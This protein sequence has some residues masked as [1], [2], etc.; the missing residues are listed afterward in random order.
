MA[1]GYS[2]IQEIVVNDSASGAWLLLA[3]ALGKILTTSLTIGSGGSGGVFGPSMVIGGCGGAALGLALHNI[4]PDLV[5]HPA[6]FAVVGMASFFAAAAKTPFS[7]LVMVSEMTG[8]YHLLLPA[9]WGCTIS[10]MASDEQSIY[11]A[12]VESRSR[13]PAHQ[14]R[15]VRDVLSD[16]RIAQFLPAGT[17]PTV[18]HAYDR[19]SLVLDQ[20]DQNSATVLPVVGDDDRLLGVVNLDEVFLA[21]QSQ[22]MLPLILAADL[23]RSQI[24]PLVPENSLDR[25]LELFVENDLRALPIVNNLREQ[26]SAGHH[27]SQ[28]SDEFLSALRPRPTLTCRQLQRQQCRV[29]SYAPSRVGAASRAHRFFAR[30]CMSGNTCGTRSHLV[31]AFFCRANGR[32]ECRAK[33]RG[34]IYAVSTSTIRRYIAMTIA[35][36]RLDKSRLRGTSGELRGMGRLLCS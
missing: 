16:I 22:E 9:L 1:A 7:T 33:H 13:S 15:Y 4:S 35:E 23:M 3:I 29:T 8:G 5:P 26:R 14:G 21:S 30:S 10:F 27:F 36:H 25:A 24:V 19:L 12:Q 34:R 18:L 28:R 17:T 6:A 20:F 32:I 2:A 11:S 31:A